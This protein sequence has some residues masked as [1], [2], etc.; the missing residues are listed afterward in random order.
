ML[1]GMDSLI[2][3]K[4]NQC[5]GFFGLPMTNRFFLFVL[6]EGGQSVFADFT[7]RQNYILELNFAVQF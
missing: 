2:K 5:T 7:S 3:R 6:E 4:H 1:D